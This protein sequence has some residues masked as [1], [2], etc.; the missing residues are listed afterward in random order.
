MTTWRPCVDRNVNTSYES[1][2]AFSASEDATANTKMTEGHWPPQDVEALNLPR[3]FV[4]FQSSVAFA[5]FIFKLED[6]PSSAGL[7]GVLCRCD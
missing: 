3:W 2:A 1:F 6:I 5:D 4:T 7:W